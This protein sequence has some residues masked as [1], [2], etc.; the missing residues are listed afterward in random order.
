MSRHFKENVT[1]PKCGKVTEITV[2]ESLNAQ[3]NPK[4]KQQL[5]DGE[6]FVF[7]C[8]CG[9]GAGI[10]SSMLYNDMEHKTMVYYVPESGKKECE[11][12]FANIRKTHSE[13]NLPEYTYRI[14]TS[15]DIIREK[16]IILDLG[17]DDRVM[18]LLKVF[19]YAQASEQY[20]EE[21]I[22]ELLFYTLNGK[23]LLQFIG[24]VSLVAEINADIY[25][26]VETSGMPAC[27][28]VQCRLVYCSHS[29]L[30]FS[31]SAV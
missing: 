14:V 25:E 9:Y 27:F 1:C 18:E 3:L 31:G 8:E 21:D 20:P 10:D 26:S 7:R 17:L 16:A 4:E 19:Y 28:M 29:F 23:W 24:S 13:F 15:R 2:W 6:L 11:E 5:M 30:S 22:Q 12:M